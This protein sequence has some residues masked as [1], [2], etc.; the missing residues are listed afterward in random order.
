MVL[1]KDSL[2]ASNTGVTCSDGT[3]D[4]AGRLLIVGLIAGRR[5]SRWLPRSVV[6][7]LQTWLES[8][9]MRNLLRLSRERLD[10]ATIPSSCLSRKK[11]IKKEQLTILFVARRDINNEQHQ[12]TFS[13]GILVRNNTSAHALRPKNFAPGETWREEV[14]CFPNKEAAQLQRPPPP[15]HVTPGETRSALDNQRTMDN[16][17][18]AQSPFKSLPL[19]LGEE[20]AW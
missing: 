2:L 13:A 8:L 3:A 18:E 9:M 11:I 17:K 7:S 1:V 4:S 14:Q 10:W 15:E 19:I 5:A 6:R 20:R 12:K 16:R